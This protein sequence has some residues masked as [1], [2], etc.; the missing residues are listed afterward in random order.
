MSRVSLHQFMRES[1]W[2]G[3]PLVWPGVNGLPFTGKTVPDL[4]GDQADNLPIKIK[5][6]SGTFDMW[7]PDSKKRYDDVC[8]H[9]ASGVWMQKHREPRWTEKGMQIWLEWYILAHELPETKHGIFPR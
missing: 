3:D 9:I 8:N 5:F 4:R 1:S 6:D 2:G 7:D